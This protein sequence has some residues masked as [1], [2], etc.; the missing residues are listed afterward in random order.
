MNQWFTRERKLEI[1]QRILVGGER[2]CSVA[3]SLDIDEKIISR[4]RREYLRDP[5]NAFSL[6]SRMPADAAL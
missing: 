4:W 1:V 6:P 2:V 5:E 3:R